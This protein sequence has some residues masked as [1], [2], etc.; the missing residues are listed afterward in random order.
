MQQVI[1]PT[2][3]LI[4]ITSDVFVSE[5]IANIFNQLLSKHKILF[6][7]DGV[8]AV[9]FMEELNPDIIVLD[10]DMPEFDYALVSEEIKRKKRDNHIIPLATSITDQVMGKCNQLGLDYCLTKSPLDLDTLRI[11]IE[12]ALDLLAINADVDKFNQAK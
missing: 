6:A 11:R 10:M 4:C 2:I 1:T 3:A 5:D 12:L 8:K 7:V 9:T